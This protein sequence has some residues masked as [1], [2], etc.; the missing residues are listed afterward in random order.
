MLHL[1]VDI[2]AHGFG[3]LAQVGPVLDALVARLPDLR[4]TIRSGLSRQRLAQRIAADFTHIAASS[5]VAF[6]MHDAVRLDRATSAQAYRLA[7]ADWPC[8]VATEAAQLRS[9]AP[10]AVFSDVSYLP[11]AGAQ[12]AGIPGAAMCSLNWADQFAFLFA[13]EKWAAPIHAEITA[14]YAGA[15]AFLRC[16]PAMPMNDLPNARAIP[17]VA[18]QGTSCRSQLEARLG[19]AGER[20]VLVAMGGLGF[21]LPVRHWPSVAG[22]RWLAAAGSSCDRADVTD[23]DGLGVHFSDLLASVDAV[24]GKPGYGTFVEAAAAGVPL[25]YLRREHWPEQDVLIEWL[26]KNAAAAEVSATAFAAGDVM[27]LLEGLWQAPRPPVAANGA[28]TAAAY[29][30]T[31]L[32][33]K[34]RSA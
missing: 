2:S 13:G 27:S 3:H 25:L 15:D 10:D 4:L 12:Q 33:A 17:P 14:A 22:V 19:R 7:H 31:L 21:E 23:Y 8:A 20:W 34:R 11:L 5:D 18:R 24:I 26:E 1:F 6:P 16:T 29:L 30:A 32:T 28:E 9:L